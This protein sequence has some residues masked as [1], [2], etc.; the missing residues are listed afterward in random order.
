M[1]SSEL[2]LRAAV[3]GSRT[4]ND[5]ARKALRDFQLAA[6]NFETVSHL[7]LDR[8]IEGK[9]RRSESVAPYLRLANQWHSAWLGVVQAAL[10]QSS[11]PDTYGDDLDTILSRRTRPGRAWSSAR[12][13]NCGSAVRHFDLADTS[14]RPSR[15]TSGC[16]GCGPLENS[17]ADTNH[18]PRISFSLPSTR[19]EQVSLLVSLAP[20]PDRSLI[21][22]RGLVQ[23]RH[24]SSGSASI[25][26]DLVFEDGSAS[27][28]FPLDP[29]SPPDI[30]SV[31]VVAVSD[32]HTSYLRRLGRLDR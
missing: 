23:F 20:D 22:P 4:T 27:C 15:I 2:R 11:E 16:A 3:L 14:A 13:D 9:S 32:F 28:S 18:R 8:L 6:S 25:L 21:A 7:A 19:G 24:K 10:L 5:A 29:E 26:T 12:C 31:R 1:T 17:T 30:Y